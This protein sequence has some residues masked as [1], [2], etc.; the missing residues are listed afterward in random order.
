MTDYPP[1]RDD[2][3]PIFGFEDDEPVPSTT[4]SARPD[5]VD[6]PAATRP[7]LDDSVA[8]DRT[9]NDSD[10]DD[11]DAD[12]GDPDDS[13]ADVSDPDDSDADDG[14]FAPR[15]RQRLGAL[16]GLLMLALAV[17]LGFLCGEIVQ[18][19]YGTAANASATTGRLAGA[20]G[21]NGNFAAGE[22]GGFGNGA[23]TGT[24]RGTGTGATTGT[25]TTPTTAVPAVIGTVSSI[26]G[27]TVVVTNLGGK[28]VTVHLTN[29]TTVTVS[30]SRRVLK[31]G[32][33]VAVSGS[34]AN[35]VVT[36]RTVVVQ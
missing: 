26:K 27:N 10:P 11:S 33:T 9:V 15:P 24:G 29:A 5:A 4:A 36:A 6:E 28:K 22:G 12:V 23:G 31:V 13:D 7:D 19:H 3:G 8:D 20:R 32:Q 2:T 1:H 21:A 17:A 14:D 16:S 34:T 25:G 35:G 30:V 18:K